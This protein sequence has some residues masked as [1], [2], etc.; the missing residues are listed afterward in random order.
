M[1]KVSLRTVV[2][3]IAFGTQ[4]AWGQTPTGPNFQVNTY[5]PG[6]QVAPS[7]GVEPDGDFVVVWASRFQ[8]GDG[9][10]VFGQRF[11]ASGATRGGEFRVNV[12]TTGSQ[13]LRT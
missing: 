10:G 8:D 9:Y 7:I 13:S 12:H 1:R 11:D 5:T 4:A 6:Q 3:V 2:L